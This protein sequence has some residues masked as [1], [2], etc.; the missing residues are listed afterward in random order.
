MGDLGGICTIQSGQLLRQNRCDRC[1][2]AEDVHELQRIGSTSTVVI[3]AAKIGICLLAA[4]PVALGSEPADRPPSLEP[5]VQYVARR[6]PEALPEPDEQVAGSLLSLEDAESL[7]LQL[8]PALAAASAEVRAARYQSWQVGRPPN[9]TLGY[10]AGE[11][12]DSGAAGQQGLFAGQTFVRGDK[13]SLNRSVAD[14][15]ASRL[16]QE[17]AAQRYRVLTDVRITF[18]ETYLAQRRVEIA[19]NLVEVGR[20]STAMA[21][22]LLDAQEG[23]RT[24]LLQAEIEGQRAAVDLAQAE[25]RHRSAWR[26]FTAALGNPTMPRITLHADLESLHW[27]LTWQETLEQL[28]QTSPEIA[29][30]LAS[31]EKARWTLSRERAEPIPDVNTQ[32]AVQYDD[33]SSTTIAGIQVSFP[34]PLWNRNQG[35]IRRAQAEI[36]SAQRQLDAAELDLTQRLAQQFQQYETARVR[37]DAIRNDILPRA[38]ENLRLVSQGYRSGELGFLDFLTV[39]RTYFRTNLEYLAALGQ[40]N[41]SVQLLNGQLLSDAFAAM[42]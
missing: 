9:P 42:Q 30:R 8:N 34:V 38:E 35:G 3:R 31:I 22:A 5:P 36:T 26:R 20:Q 32:L 18:Y 33:A 4:A 16:E 19:R 24:D 27:Q 13:L 28:L 14:R 23:R 39:Q 21:Q 6:L 7:A 15:E 25:S 12:G 17:F 41:Q 1:S 11:I 2:L 29:S 37:V 40:L 10:T